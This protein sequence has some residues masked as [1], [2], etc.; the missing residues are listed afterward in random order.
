[1]NPIDEI[2]FVDGTRRH[3]YVDREGRQ[4]VLD[5]DDS[6]V[7]GNW[8]PPDNLPDVPEIVDVPE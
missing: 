6:R 7:Y 1:M 5:D 4:H 2:P 8:I 3:V